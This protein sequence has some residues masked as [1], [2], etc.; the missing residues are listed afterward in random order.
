[1]KLKEA[2]SKEQSLHNKDINYLIHNTSNKKPNYSNKK[3]PV[4]C[5]KCG[6]KF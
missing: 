2:M 4:I 1:M 6:H 5:P 3:K